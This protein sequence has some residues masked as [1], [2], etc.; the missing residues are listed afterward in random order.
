MA[1]FINLDGAIIF[2]LSTALTDR[3]LGDWNLG[4]A[5]RRVHG[6][7]LSGL[8]SYQAFGAALECGLNTTV[9]QK[10]N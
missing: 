10:S 6:L 4:R 2:R 9:R 8:V 5:F 3:A 7:G 1:P